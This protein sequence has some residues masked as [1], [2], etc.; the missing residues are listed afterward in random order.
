ML[1][2]FPI[3][4][5]PLRD[6]VLKAYHENRG[7]AGAPRALLA[8]VRQFLSGAPGGDSVPGRYWFEED[9]RAS[10]A[11]YLDDLDGAAP[12]LAA[13]VMEPLLAALD[14]GEKQRSRELAPNLPVFVK[15]LAGSIAVKT[16]LDETLTGSAL[17]AAILGLAR[18]G[19]T[20]FAEALERR[21]PAGEERP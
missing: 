8:A 10:V 3:D 5:E 17:A 18:A 4:E 7:A 16:G 6:A 11:S 12:D 1:G 13:L 19:R 20:P 14:K 2:G 15:S 21:R 9:P